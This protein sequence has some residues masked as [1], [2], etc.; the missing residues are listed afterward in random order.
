MRKI[1]ALTLVSILLILFCGAYVSAE[2][3]ALLK[4]ETD[5]TEGY[6]GDVVTLSLRLS[7]E[8]LGGIQ[9]DIQ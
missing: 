7:A 6:G 1:L 8:K 9:T 2:S 4:L 5:I 3:A